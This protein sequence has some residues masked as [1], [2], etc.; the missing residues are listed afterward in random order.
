MTGV[1]LLLLTGLVGILTPTGAAPL[2]AE[3][4]RGR[5][6]LIDL[7]TYSCINWLR[8]LP[9]V[10]AWEEE[11]RAQG[12]VVIGVHSPEFAFEHEGQNLRRAVQAMGVRYPVAV[13]NDFTIWRFREQ[14]LARALP[15]ECRGP[16]QVPAFRGR[17]L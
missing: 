3:N 10:R 4:L 16:D 17:G 5:V 11:Y 1:R 12:L 6:V 14:C 7:W 8:T 15:G 13:D 2:T 9:Y